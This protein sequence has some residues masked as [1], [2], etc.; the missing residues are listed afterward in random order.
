MGY[1]WSTIEHQKQKLVDRVA[2]GL[3]WR[4]FDHCIV[5]VTTGKSLCQVLLVL[6]CEKWVRWAISW[7]L[8]AN[9]IVPQ[10]KQEGT[11]WQLVGQWEAAVGEE[12]PLW[13]MFAVVSGLQLSTGFPFDT[14]PTTT[15][16]ISLLFLPDDRLTITLYDSLNY[17]HSPPTFLWSLADHI[18]KRVPV[19]LLLHAIK[20]M[21]VN[22]SVL[23]LSCPP[24]CLLPQWGK[25]RLHGAQ[26]QV[27]GCVFGSRGVSRKFDFCSFCSCAI[28]DD[29][30]SVLDGFVF[31][32]R[33]LTF[34]SG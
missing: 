11:R 25:S 17:S 13:E 8:T 10:R 18:W 5:S 20:S 1:R 28:W 15:V 27:Q 16:R 22:C 21:V 7:S 9:H 26:S 14:T 12:A 34:I 32:C 29:R 3:C 24:P 23:P 19:F 31:P 6:T 33:Y 2:L 30:L 4:L